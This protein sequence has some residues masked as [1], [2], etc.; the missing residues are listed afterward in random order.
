MEIARKGDIYI[1]Y[2]KGDICCN[3]SLRMFTK[4]FRL[5]SPAKLSLS[6]HAG[7]S[8]PD[9]HRRDL[10]S[11]SDPRL[12][13]LRARPPAWGAGGC[14]RADTHITLVYIRLPKPRGIAIVHPSPHSARVPQLPSWSSEVLH[15]WGLPKSYPASL[16]SDGGTRSTPIGALPRR[17]VRIRHAPSEVHTMHET[18]EV[19]ACM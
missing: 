12:L 13:A 18:P 3:G 10:G 1:V 5:A 6:L 14:W 7:V 9:V 11:S 19:R 4:V 17:L 16:V 2:W 15:V 8:D